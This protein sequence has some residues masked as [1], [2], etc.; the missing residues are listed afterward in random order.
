MCSCVFAFRDRSPTRE[1]HLQFV[2]FLC[3]RWGDVEVEFQSLYSNMFCIPFEGQINFRFL[4]SNCYKFRPL[5]TKKLANIAFRYG[6]FGTKSPVPFTPPGPP[7][8]PPPV[9]LPLA[10]CKAASG[11]LSLSLS[12]SRAISLRR[13]LVVG[14]KKRW[15]ARTQTTFPTSCLGLS[16]SD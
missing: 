8:G 13:A 11:G 7:P 10:V 14:P 15:N 2:W 16:P 3:F 4:N 5:K 1:G 12:F 6:D 9:L